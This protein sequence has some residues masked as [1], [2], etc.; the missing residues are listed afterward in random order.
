M[1]FDLSQYIPF[2]AFAFIWIA[3]MLAGFA[4]ASRNDNKGE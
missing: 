2:N 4:F 1:A 3:C